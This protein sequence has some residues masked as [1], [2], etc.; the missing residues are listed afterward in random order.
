[1][2]GQTQEKTLVFRAEK[3]R[4]SQTGR[5]Y[6]WIVRNSA[7]VNHYCVYE[8]DLDCGPSLL[9]FCIHLRCNSKFGI[10]GHKYVKRQLLKEKL[11]FDGLDNTI[12]TCTNFRRFQQ[13]YNGLSVARNDTQLCAWLVPLL[14][15]FTANRPAAGYCFDISILLAEFSLKQ[16]LDESHIRRVFFEE[17]SRG[18]Q[19]MRQADH[20]QL[21][22]NRRI[23]K[24]DPK[25]FRRC[26]K[27][28]CV[29]WT[30]TTINDSRHLDKRLPNRP[31]LRQLGFQTDRLHED[32]QQISQDSK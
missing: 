2:V 26:H 14:H 11:N 31:T 8:I 27:E 5:P 20:V 3:C 18:N 23:S 16:I 9:K 19:N 28:D 4:N 30:E 15:S 7:M 1:M 22:S 10:D 13:L 12:L 6:R 29:L 24:C 17:V 21:I 32:V 25:Q